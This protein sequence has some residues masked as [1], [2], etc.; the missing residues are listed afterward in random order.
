MRRKR[1]SYAC[2]LCGTPCKEG[3]RCTV[4]V[5]IRVACCFQATV[6]E[7]LCRLPD[8]FFIYTFV[9]CVPSLRFSRH[10]ISVRR[11]IYDGLPHNY[12]KNTFCILISDQVFCLLTLYPIGGVDASPLSRPKA[13]GQKYDRYK[14]ARLHT[15]TVRECI[16]AE[17]LQIIGIS[18][19][20]SGLHRC[21]Y[22]CLP[23]RP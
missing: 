10:V 11:C 6:D 13:V 16:L 9:K 20:S 15:R 19:S 4:K 18:L 5:E 17:T 7:D 12:P 2:A 23:R 3:K 8:H 1:A 14:V 22:R 21:Q